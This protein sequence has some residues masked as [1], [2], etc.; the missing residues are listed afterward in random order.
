[1]SFLLINKH[2]YAVNLFVSFNVSQQTIKHQILN[3]LGK[4]SN[5]KSQENLS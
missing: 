4:T 1:M 5:F 2:F 3:L